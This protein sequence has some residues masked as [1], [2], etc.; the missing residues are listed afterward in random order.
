MA[1]FR[2]SGT[3]RSGTPPKKAKALRCSRSHV[4]TVWSKTNSTYW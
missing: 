2:L 1:A 4:S 3:I